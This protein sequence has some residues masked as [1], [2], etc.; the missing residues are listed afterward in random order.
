VEIPPAEQTLAE[1]AV[2]ALQAIGVSAA[3]VDPATPAQD[4]LGPDVAPAFLSGSCLPVPLRDLAA[5]LVQQ[6][7][8]AALTLLGHVCR[9]ATHPEYAVAG[10]DAILLQQRLRALASLDAQ[11]SP[12]LDSYGA[13]PVFRI[14]PGAAEK[15]VLSDIREQL[16]RFRRRFGLPERRLHAAKFSFY[17]AA[18]DLREGLAGA[19]YDPARERPFLEAAVT[20]KAPVETVVSRYKSA[21]ALVTGHPFTP[22]LWA[23]L[24]FLPRVHPAFLG[25]GA[26]PAATARKTQDRVRRPVPE[27]ALG[28]HGARGLE[29]ESAVPGD[30]ALSDLV[31]DL[32]RLID[33]GLSD[34]EIAEALPDVLGRAVRPRD[35]AYYRERR[36]EFGGG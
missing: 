35:V 34:A 28:P 1:W 15:T 10:D 33:A 11:V 3:P 17:F 12:G 8:R 6:L 29:T 7:S 24:F 27:S 26:G 21:F 25:S 20:L 19:G 4:L 30:A 36:A 14:N 32:D 31:M 22:A 13:R 16:R 5:E 23:R 2:A 9:A 18:W